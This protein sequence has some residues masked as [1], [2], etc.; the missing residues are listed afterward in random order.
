[1]K[2]EVI[3]HYNRLRACYD[4]TSKLSISKSTYH[5]RKSKEWV[6]AF[7]NLWKDVH[8]FD[9]NTAY[10]IDNREDLILITQGKTCLMLQIKE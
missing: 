5:L 4:S 8:G 2:E 3:Y 10:L 1:M 7:I 9:K 6:E